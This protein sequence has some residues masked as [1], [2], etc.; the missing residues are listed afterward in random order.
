MTSPMRQ[1]MTSPMRQDMTSPERQDVALPPDYE[2]D[3]KRPIYA[4]QAYNVFSYNVQAINT[5]ASFTTPNH[6]N[7][8]PAK[9][10]LRRDTLKKL[11]CHLGKFK[12]RCML[13]ETDKQF[14][15]ED[16]HLKHRDKTIRETQIQWSDYSEKRDRQID[17]IDK[18][19]R[20]VRLYRVASDT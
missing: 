5:T 18:A 9:D 6:R 2:E 7:N 16:N 14:F 20:K 17:I 12:D 11:N 4:T 15:W 13:P 1:D 8:Y 3:G 19:Q 10:S